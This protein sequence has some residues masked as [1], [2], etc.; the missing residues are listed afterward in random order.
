MN[1]RRLL[2]LGLTVCLMVFAFGVASAYADN[3]TWNPE[4]M[5]STVTLSNNNLTANFD[6]VDCVRA[7][8]GRNSGKYYYELSFSSTSN[9]MMLGICSDTFDVDGNYW[10]SDDSIFYYSYT[11][12][13]YTTDHFAY[14]ESSLASDI[15]GV[16]LNLDDRE[17]NFYKN[18]VPQGVISFNEVSSLTGSVFPVCAIASTQA[19]IT[20]NFGA[21]PFTYSIPEGYQAYNESE[22]TTNTTLDIE[23]TGDTVNVGDTFT[24]DV[25]INNASNLYAED[26]KITYDTTLFEYQGYT[27]VEG[28]TVYDSSEAT[29]G[30]LRFIVASDGQANVVNGDQVLLQ[31]NFRALAE[32][33]GLVDVISGRVADTTEEYDIA[34]EDCGDETITV[35]GYN[36]VNR[37]GEFTL[38]DLAIDAYYLGE[39]AEN[40]D[41][42]QYDCDVVEDGT[43]TI[44]DLTAIV[45]EILVNTNYTPNS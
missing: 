43:I 42:T 30:I 13:K 12:K 2:L 35:E 3:V 24:T 9:R 7:T 33:E 4:D 41:T 39:T 11:G 28:L 40:T 8:I 10:R 23:Y 29:A 15:I 1:K 6:G 18:S 38:L 45:T 25:V 16:A 36:D 17:V 5:G 22:P 14:G 34:V 21:T 26:F 20:A 32:G 27:E 37:S 31:L 19:D 44:D